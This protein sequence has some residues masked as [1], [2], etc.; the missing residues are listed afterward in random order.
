MRRLDS[1]LYFRDLAVADEAYVL[2]FYQGLDLQ[3]VFLW[4]T[5]PMK[6]AMTQVRKFQG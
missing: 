2:I 1:T 5:V 4:L 3:R 6:K